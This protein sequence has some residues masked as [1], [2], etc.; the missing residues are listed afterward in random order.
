MKPGGRFKGGRF[1]F[2]GR[3][4]SLSNPWGPYTAGG[5]VP[6]VVSDFRANLHRGLNG[7]AVAFADLFDFSRSTVGTYT[8]SSGVVSTAAIGE[9]RYD[10]VFEDGQWVSRGLFVE[11]QARTNLLLRSSDFGNSAWSCTRSSITPNAGFGPDVSM[12]ATRL[13]STASTF[14]GAVR[15]SMSYTLGDTLTFSIHAKAGDRPYVF[16]ANE[17]ADL[18]RIPISI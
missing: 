14:D 8:N 12:S 3:T 18:Q 4:Q 11:G 17:R 7:Q 9:L 1:A 10:H 5:F 6:D 13:T 16:C 2:N 15:Q